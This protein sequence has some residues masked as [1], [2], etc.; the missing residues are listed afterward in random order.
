SGEISGKL[1]DALHR[2]HRYYNEEGTRKL[3]DFAQWTPRLIYGLV[4]CIIGYKIIQFYT[5]YFNQ[6]STITNGF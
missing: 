2:L 5:G 6:I 1:D 4:A 3:Q